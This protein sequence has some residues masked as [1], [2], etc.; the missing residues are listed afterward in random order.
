MKKR[1]AVA[2]GG[3]VIAV[4]GV[5]AFATLSLRAREAS[6]VGDPRLDAPVVRLATATP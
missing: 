5:A 4:L 2:L 6:A 1:P 3:L